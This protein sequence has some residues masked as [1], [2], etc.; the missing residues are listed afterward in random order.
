[1]KSIPIFISRSG[2]VESM[3]MNYV[4]NFFSVKEVWCCVII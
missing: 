2:W 3:D 1:M 4:R